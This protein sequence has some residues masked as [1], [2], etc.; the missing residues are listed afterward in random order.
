MK[1]AR[2]RGKKYNWALVLSLFLSPGLFPQQN[3]TQN[4]RQASAPTTQASNPQETSDQSA[5][6]SAPT[7]PTFVGPLQP[8]SSIAFEAGPLGKLN[9]DGVASAIGFWQSNN[10]PGDNSVHPAINSGMLYLQKAS[11]PVQFYIQ[12]GAYNIVS[13]GT[14]FIQTD[15]QVTDLWG[16]IPVAYLKFS[17][18]EAT[19]IQIGSLPTLMGAEY[20]FDFQNIN[21][22][23]GLLWNQE[24]A[25]NRG[26]QINQILG[27]FTASFS[28]NDGFFSNRYSW[29]SGA[30]TYANGAH[31]L[32]FKAMGNLGQTAFVSLATPLQNNSTMYAVVYTY[33]KGKWVVN[34][35]FQYTSVPTDPKIGIAK[36][37]S[38]YGGAFLLSR[39]IARGFSLA[40]RGE[41]I[42]SNG[43]VQ[44]GSVNLL[45]GPGSS[46]WS[47][48]VTPTYQY[49]KFFTR[50]DLAWVRANSITPGS[51]FGPRGLN[52]NQPRGVIEAGFM[53]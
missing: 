9:F 36:G 43:S 7:T 31:S 33:T 19:S 53:F 4:T 5:S 44:E 47:A 30:L 12:A 8:P 39:R 49:K 27:E 42:A 17:P 11:G 50:V 6:P 35:Y 22:Q 34:P 16:P 23:R 40:G 20:T 3:G 37:S 10:I 13:L 32:S 48:T 26:I 45:Y 38:T 25:T 24:N 51:A 2:N 28:W 14:P 21:V 15:K 18:T 29:L 46:A 1:E 52:R 41:Y